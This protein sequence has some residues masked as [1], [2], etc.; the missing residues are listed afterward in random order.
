MCPPPTDRGP[1]TGNMCMPVL[2]K[3]RH[4]PWHLLICH[5]IVTDSI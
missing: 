1:A 3:M 5:L 2:L 4:A